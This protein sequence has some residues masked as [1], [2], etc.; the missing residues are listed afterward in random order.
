M[1]VAL[2]IFTSMC[3]SKYLSTGQLTTAT[4]VPTAFV[5]SIIPISMALSIIHNIVDVVVDF[6][7]HD[8]APKEVTE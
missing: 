6:M 8:K 4:K 1:V 5:Y 7:P 2:F 3:F